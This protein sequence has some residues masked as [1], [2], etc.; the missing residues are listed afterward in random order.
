MALYF[1]RNRVC[2]FVANQEGSN[3]ETVERQLVDATMSYFKNMREKFIE[4]IQQYIKFLLQ[5]KEK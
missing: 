1:V 2:P 4:K 5:I 3:I